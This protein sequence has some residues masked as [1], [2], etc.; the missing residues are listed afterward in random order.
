MHDDMIFLYSHFWIIRH[1]P[2]MKYTIIHVAADGRYTYIGTKWT[3]RTS[4]P[5]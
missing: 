2:C 3:D 5:M 1:T 4:K